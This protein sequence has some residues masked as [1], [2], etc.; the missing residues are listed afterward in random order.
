MLEVSTKTGR[1]MDEWLRLLELRRDD[2]IGER[3]ASA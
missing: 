1:G 3:E 2:R